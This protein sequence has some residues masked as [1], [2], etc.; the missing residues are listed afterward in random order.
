MKLIALNLPRDVTENELAALFKTYGNIQA[1]DLVLDAQT[2]TS[3]GFGF[4]QMALEHE[5]VMAMIGLNNSM[6]RNNR[7]RVKAAN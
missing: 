5:G 1:C 7:I 3:K 2:G 4:V 6:L